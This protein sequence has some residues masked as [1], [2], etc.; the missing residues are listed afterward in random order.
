MSQNRVKIG[1]PSAGEYTYKVHGE[2]EVTPLPASN[3][4]ARELGTAA[5]QYQQ[6]QAERHRIGEEMAELALYQVALHAQNE[7]P[8]AGFIRMEPEYD[9]GAMS[10]SAVLDREGNILGG[11]YG[12][13]VLNS[14]WQPF[15]DWKDR[16][17]ID[18]LTED[19]PQQDSSWFQHAESEDGDYSSSFRVSL[20]DV[21]RNGA[22]VGP[23]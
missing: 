7:F 23:A 3:G 8:R 4:N 20:Q 6:A 9:T 2:A 22:R 18:R 19:L 15:H 17:G 5:A 21:A 16:A 14:I 12:P 13:D 11:D 10:V 1:I